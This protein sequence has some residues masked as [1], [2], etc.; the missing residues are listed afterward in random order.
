VEAFAQEGKGGDDTEILYEYGSFCT[1]FRF[2]SMRMNKCLLIL[3]PPRK[4]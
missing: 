1:E 3:V 4:C 2:K